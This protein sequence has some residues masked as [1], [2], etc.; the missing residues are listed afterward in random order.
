LLN[1]DSALTLIRL[2][3]RDDTDGLFFAIS[4]LSAINVDDQQHRALC[5]SKGSAS[6]VVCNAG[7]EGYRTQAGISSPLR[8]GFP[9]R[10]FMFG[11]CGGHELIDARAILAAQPFHRHP[12]ALSRP[13]QVPE[14]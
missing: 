9:P 14:V 3:G 11:H 6:D 10:R 4:L 8:G 5:G 12:V 7:G 2:A 13:V 1:A